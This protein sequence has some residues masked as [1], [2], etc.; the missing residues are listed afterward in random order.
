MGFKEFWL[1]KP[2]PITRENVSPQVEE[3]ADSNGNPSPAILPPSRTAFGIGPR[4][5]ARIGSVYRCVNIISTMISQMPLEVFRDEKKLKTPYLIQNPVEGESQAAFVQ[6][7][8]WSLALWGNCF[9]RL[10]GD[11]VSSV[12]V[13]APD[14]VTVTKENGKVRYYLGPKE[15]PADRIRHLKFERMPGELLGHGPL[16]GCAGELKAAYLLDQFQRTWFDTTG[17]PKGVLTMPG[18]S[19]TNASKSADLVTSWNEFIKGNAGTVILPGGMTYEAIAAKPIEVQYVEVAE[20]NI[21]NIAR[22]F[23]IPA[24]NL[25]SAIEGTSMTYTNQIESNIQFL[26]NTLSRYMIEIENFLS[27][28]LPRGQRVEFNEE[29]LLRLAPEKLWGVRKVQYEVGYYDGAEQRKEEGKPP[30]P[31]KEAVKPT[32]SEQANSEKEVSN[33]GNGN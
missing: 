18:G 9:V 27:T 20:A 12:E 31:K 4:E 14:S 7:V 8:V 15:V 21:R 13:L 19:T 25:L 33:N 23:G 32:A 17:I 26:Q 2:E 3:R 24:A 29:E 30:L 6:E 11:P 1:G 28:L 22:I 5:A 16:T 10:Y